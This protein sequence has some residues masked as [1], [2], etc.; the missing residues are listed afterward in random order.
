MLQSQLVDLVFTGGADT[1]TDNKN[2]LFTKFQVLENVRVDKVGAVRPRGG[3]ISRNLAPASAG[4]DA[5]TSQSFGSVSSPDLHLELR[6]ASSYRVAA[7]ASPLLDK[8]ILIGSE[9]RGEASREVFGNTF[10]GTAVATT[11]TRIFSAWVTPADTKFYISASI[12]DLDGNEILQTTYDPGTA[13]SG[14][15]LKIEVIDNRFLIF[16]SGVN[17]V[18]ALEVTEQELNPVTPITFS[19]GTPQ[20]VTT[21]NSRWALAS[22]GLDLYFYGGNSTAPTLSRYSLS[23]STFTFST[24]SAFAPGTASLINSVAILK[25]DTGINGEFIALAGTTGTGFAYLQFVSQLLVQIGTNRTVSS[26]NNCDSVWIAQ[27]DPRYFDWGF[28]EYPTAS[29]RLTNI[30]EADV[31]P[32]FNTD[33]LKAAYEFNAIMA[34]YPFY[35]EQRLYAPMVSFAPITY[36]SSA[37]VEIMY[38]DPGC[39]C[40]IAMTYGV[41]LNV[42][43]GSQVALTRI[44]TVG[45]KLVIPSPIPTDVYL[46][47]NGTLSDNTVVGSNVQFSVRASYILIDTDKYTPKALNGNVLLGSTPRAAMN[48]RQSAYAWAELRDGMFSASSGALSGVYSYVAAKTL[49]LTDGTVYRSY[50]PIFTSKLASG[51]V[52]CTLTTSDFAVPGIPNTARITIEIYRT[53]TNG[54]IFY[55]D[56]AYTA[57]GA[58]T[59]GSETAL[60]LGR[61]A[62]I[63][64]GELYPEPA[65]A[66]KAVCEWKDRLAAVMVDR[67]TVIKFNRPSIYPVGLSFADG[68]E[69]DVG[70][71]DGPITALA[72]MDQSLYVFHRNSLKTVAGDPAGATGLNGSLTT[73]TILRDGLGTTNPRSVVLTP[74]G[75]IFQSAKGFYLIMRNQEWVFIGDGPYDFRELQVTGAAVD[76]TQSEVYFTYRQGIWVYN[77]GT[78]Q[79]YRWSPPEA[80]YGV[81]LNKNRVFLSSET[82]FAEYRT[83][84]L[85]DEITITNYQIQ[86]RCMTG[87]LRPDHIRG[88]QRVKRLYIAGKSLEPDTVTIRIYTD[89]NDDAPVQTKTFT[90][91][92]QEKVEFDLHLAVQKCEAMKF[93]I[94]TTKASLI[95]SGASIELGVKTGVDKSRTPNPG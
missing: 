80:T 73:P 91:E 25:L 90:Y 28:T 7:N 13:V 87:W 60:L 6:D 27:R 34:N 71:E 22:S 29:T 85:R 68:L 64:S 59:W 45:S 51:K 58:V 30:R 5:L 82:G 44:A 3:I 67:P 8:E 69:L 89:Y 93:D 15:S 57:P 61:F 79:W 16:Y 86:Q 83:S 52:D 11:A 2:T 9:F 42:L 12:K 20:T 38:R 50:G 39:P 47:N 41:S 31:D 62:D 33:V 43:P 81:S 26:V 70:K 78:D 14:D 75:I 23:G 56:R 55:L 19:G 84:S 77:Y 88:Y 48:Y 21:P 37:L 92:P 54:T 40:D 10:R 49:T 36:G 18:Y 53:Q 65:G 17:T 35:H 72:A 1:K 4:L 66:I 74:R 24:S 94:R 95:L 76:E 46:P 32:F 63:N